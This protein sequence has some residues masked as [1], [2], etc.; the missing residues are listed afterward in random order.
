MPQAGLIVLFIVGK[1]HG[2]EQ[3][4]CV[5]HLSISLMW[6]ELIPYYNLILHKTLFYGLL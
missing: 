3:R 6:S 4:L 5:Q 1:F 2:Q